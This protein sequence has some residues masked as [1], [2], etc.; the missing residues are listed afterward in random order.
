MHSKRAH[1]TDMTGTY[2]YCTDPSSHWSLVALL[3]TV[4]TRCAN[5]ARRTRSASD[6]GGE[7]GIASPAYSFTSRWFNQRLL[8][9]IVKWR[10]ATY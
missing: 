1:C 4:M 10:C 8:V 5:A 7:H 9:M 6:L 2:W 3:I